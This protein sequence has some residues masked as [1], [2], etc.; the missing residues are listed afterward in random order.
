M[1]QSLSEATS[2]ADIL[3]LASPSKQKCMSSDL[4]VVRCVWRHR[5]L[6][7]SLHRFG[8]SREAN[9]SLGQKVI[10]YFLCSPS[11]KVTQC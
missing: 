8:T 3:Q 2:R 1:H 6:F 11:R 7:F 5:L 10:H 4:E 9:W